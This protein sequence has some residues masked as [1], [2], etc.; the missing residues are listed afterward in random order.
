MSSLIDVSNS[1][2]ASISDK[3]TH[4]LLGSFIISWL[5]FN[6]KAVYF[7]LFSD[8]DV[9]YKLKSVSENYSDLDCN[10]LYPL[11]SS[12]TLGIFLPMF[13]ARYTRF[14]AKTKE[15]QIKS[16]PELFESHRLTLEESNS[17]RDYYTKEF[18]SLKSELESAT[19]E[20]TKYRTEGQSKFEE[21]MSKNTS[22]VNDIFDLFAA[23]KISKGILKAHLSPLEFN[24]VIFLEQFLGGYTED[25]DLFP[26]E[27]YIYSTHQYM[28]ELCSS[29]GLI[30]G[31]ENTIF[32]STEGIETLTHLK[33]K[34]FQKFYNITSPNDLNGR[35]RFK[36]D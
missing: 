16:L 36:L 20:I 15:Y 13:T 24:Q 30:E 34:A 23:T 21:E 17:L 32:L 14:I 31:L 7:M 33:Y 11:A 25:S 5:F 9:V 22:K 12:I 29:Q 6:W 18:N 28:V 26:D 1:I 35:E 10:L 2:K 19:K 3:A 4:P 27:T 8:L